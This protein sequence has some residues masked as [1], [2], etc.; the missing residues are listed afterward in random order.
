MPFRLSGLGKPGWGGVWADMGPGP[1]WSDLSH[2][3]KRGT[4]TMGGTLIVMALVVTT[5]LWADLANRFVWVAIIS[6]CGF[7][8]IGWIDDR[9]K[10]LTDD[11]AG[12]SATT[13]FV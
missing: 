3:G 6:C 9:R 13:K 10:L 2:F 11:A 5:L 8:V 4:P 1:S 7:A 12:L